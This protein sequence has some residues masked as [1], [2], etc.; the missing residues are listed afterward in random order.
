MVEVP[1]DG[2]GTIWVEVDEPEAEGGTERAGRFG[3]MIDTV[4]AKISFDDALNQVCSATERVI[5]KLRGL[6]DQ[7][8]EVEMEF[9]FKMGSEIVASIAKVTSEGNYKVTLRWKGDKSQGS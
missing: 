5:V 6:S 2:G 8:D 7:P 9:G 4:K 1:L 3:D